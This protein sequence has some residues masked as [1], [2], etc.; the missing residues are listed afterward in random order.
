MWRLC[1]SR[2]TT[3]VQDGIWK[4]Q[5][6][7]FWLFLINFWGC[8]WLSNVFGWSR[9]PSKSGN[10]SR[11]VMFLAR[12]VELVTLSNTLYSIDVH[13]LNFKT[14]FLSISNI[15]NNSVVHVIPK[16]S[17]SLSFDSG[18]S[19]QTELHQ[20]RIFRLGYPLPHKCIQ[21]HASTLRQ[22]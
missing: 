18:V 16:G 21:R 22:P 2:L 8:D 12:R 13:P 5:P 9:R 7:N 3:R 15:V 14:I 17:L 19:L 6:V 10:Y 11:V 4:K 20:R 1:Y